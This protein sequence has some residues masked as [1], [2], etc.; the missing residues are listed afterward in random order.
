MSQDDPQLARLRAAFATADAPPDPQSCPAAETIWSA[1][2][3]EL[4]PAQMREVVEHTA[5]CSACAEDWR[6]AA[7]L[8]RQPIA[9]ADADGAGV[10]PRRL[11]TVVQGRFGG[12]RRWRPLAAAA[13]LAAGLLIAVGVYQTGVYH[14]GS[15]SPQE[16]AYREASH[17][18]IR[19][20]LPAG[21][22]LPRQAAVLRWSPL[23]GA[24]GYDVQVSTEDLASVATAKG[25]TAARYR[26]AASALAS[27]PRGTKL[28]WRV[29]AVRA[30]GS[31][32]ASP[33]FSTPLD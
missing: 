23:P 26:I 24:T 17:A 27:L 21:E 2:R 32:E 9:D 31:H 30:D 11:G 14:S 5:R 19:S 3:G 22:A 4:P 28:L 13:A 29:D 15:L 8:N 33:T 7:E 12:W 18:G 25:L 10:A 20:L 1:V 16:P 6:L